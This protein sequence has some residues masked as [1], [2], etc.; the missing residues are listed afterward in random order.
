[1]ERDRRFI[2]QRRRGQ[3]M[4]KRTNPQYRLKTLQKFT[5]EPVQN[6]IEEEG[7]IKNEN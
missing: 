4:Q 7:E 6:N 5:M 1:M 2:V 3:V